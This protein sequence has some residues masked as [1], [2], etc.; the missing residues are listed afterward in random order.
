[1][2]WAHCSVHGLM[3]CAPESV[4]RI[5]C[6]FLFCISWENLDGKKEIQHILLCVGGSCQIRLTGAQ[7]QSVESSD[8]EPRVKGLGSL[9]VC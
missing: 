8:L 3:Q 4:R 6:T 1:M 7:M 9:K 5:S 2:L